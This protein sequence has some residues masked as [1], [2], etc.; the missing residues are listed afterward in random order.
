[1]SGIRP[2]QFVRRHFRAAVV[3]AALPLVV[4][5]GRTV[6]GCGCFGHFESPCHCGCCSDLQDAGTQRGKA[7]CSSCTGPVSSYGIRPCCSDT[8]PTNLSDMADCDSQSDSSRQWQC[9]HCK[10]IVRYE[11]TPATVAPSVDANDFHEPN[12]V[13]TNV[14]MAHIFSQAPVRRAADCD[15][16]PPPKDLVI[17]LQRLVI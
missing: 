5:S 15:I 13:F 12:F 17:T 4:F 6:V 11:V 9:N 1:M 10:L 2:A 16:G 8:E 7:A 14:A 3:W